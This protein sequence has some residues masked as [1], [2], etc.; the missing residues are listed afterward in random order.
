MLLT[1]LIYEEGNWGPRVYSYS[2][3]LLYLFSK[4]R[5]QQQ[6]GDFFARSF[7]LFCISNE[8]NT[9]PF[10]GSGRLFSVCNPGNYREEAPQVTAE[11]GLLI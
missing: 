1:T 7:V 11:K 5:S 6:L 9:N 8:P 2:R 4:T 3:G 10:L